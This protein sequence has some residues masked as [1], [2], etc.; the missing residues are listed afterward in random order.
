MAFATPALIDLVLSLVGR[1]QK[2]AEVIKNARDA[3][4][5]VTDS[6][7]NELMSGDDEAR[8]QLRTAVEA[9]RAREL[10]AARVPRGD[11]T[12]AE[13]D[14]RAVATPVTKPVPMTGLGTATPPKP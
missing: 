8:R 11:E 2:A 7:L 14:K 1:L 10:E 9:A 4:R 5:D 13:A 6:E 12:Q 3:G